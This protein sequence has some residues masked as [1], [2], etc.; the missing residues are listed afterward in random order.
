MPLGVNLE[1]H[2][3]LVTSLAVCCYV[4]GISA[5]VALKTSATLPDGETLIIQARLLSD[6]PECRNTVKI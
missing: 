2:L 5:C 6:V 4:D 3:L 1:G